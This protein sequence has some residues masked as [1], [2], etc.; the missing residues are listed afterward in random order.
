MDIAGCVEIECDSERVEVC[1]NN[2]E[3]IFEELGDILTKH[4]FLSIQAGFVS[5]A[6]LE[7][8]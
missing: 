5:M 1:P 8:R 3:D 6:T 4:F 7:N 2:T